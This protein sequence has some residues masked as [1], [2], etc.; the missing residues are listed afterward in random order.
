MTSKDVDQI[1][2]VHMSSWGKNVILTK[3][4]HQFLRECFYG[5]IV[6]SKDAFGYV[7]CEGDKIIGYA[8]GFLDYPSFIHKNPKNA[9]GKLIALWRFL[10]FKLSWK[11]ILDALSEKRKY[12]NLKNPKFHLGALALRNEYKGTPKGREAITSAIQAVLDEIAKK[13]APSVWGITDKNN[14]PMIKY[15]FRLGFNFVEEIKFLNR[16]DVLF[17]K[18]FQ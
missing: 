18:T 8:T 15:L 6:R 14:I 13:K 9:L 17:E 4:G 2:K 16:T 12:K 7:Y 10:A 1:I 3:L 11:D 5:Q